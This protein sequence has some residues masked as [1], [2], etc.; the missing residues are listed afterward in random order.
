M[1]IDSNFD[2]LMQGNKYSE[3]GTNKYYE[4]YQPSHRL[5]IQSVDHKNHI[6]WSLDGLPGERGASGLPGPDGNNNDMVKSI[7]NPI[8]LY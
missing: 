8:L 3:Q 6:T 1:Y 7:M 2:Y 4:T 5:Y